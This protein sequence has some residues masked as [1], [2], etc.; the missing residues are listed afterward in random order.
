VSDNST[1][2][3]HG[4]LTE[5]ERNTLAGRYKEYYVN[6]RHNFFS[7][8]QRFPY[9]WNCFTQLDQIVERE[10][11]SMQRVREPGIM[12]PTILYM[13]AHA[14]MRIAF[15]LGCSTSLP[16][17]HSIL[18][19]A[20]ESAAHAHRLASDPKLLMPWMKKNDD[21]AAKKVFK[22]EFEH[23]KAKQLFKGLPELH[24]L[25][26]QF[27]EFGS[28]TNMNSIVSR[29]VITQT[30]TDLQFGLNYLG[31]D[32]AIFVPALF[33]MILAF[34]LIEKMLFKLAQTRLALDPQLVDMRTEFEKEKEATRVLVIKT[35]GLKRPPP[36]S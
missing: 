16:E 18:R 21:E 34:S 7:T 2:T 23:N 25:W 33:E 13:N 36:K 12:F 30:E 4:L 9:L 19:D 1:P 27:S 28:H 14:K 3:E 24:K 29:F 32:P 26:G 31:G 6:K 5:F 15:E 11:S 22:Q 8:I 10:F 35:F 17:A 20:I